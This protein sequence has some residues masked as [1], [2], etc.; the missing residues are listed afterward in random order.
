MHIRWTVALYK[1]KK[2]YGAFIELFQYGS[3][4]VALYKPDVTDD[5]APYIGEEA[6]LII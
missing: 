3:L 4:N 2:S 1:V 6:Y 5:Q